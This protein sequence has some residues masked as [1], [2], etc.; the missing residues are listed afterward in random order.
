VLRK[1]SWWVSEAGVILFERMVAIAI[2]AIISAATLLLWQKQQETYFR[3]TEAA[4][5]QQDLRAALQVII[6][7]VRQARTVVTAESDRIV[8]QSAAEADPVPQRTLTLGT[9]SGC[10]PLCMLYNRGDGTGAQPIAEGLVA[11]TFVYRDAND[12]VLTAPVSAAQLKDIRQIDIAL[13]GQMVMANP[14]PPFSFSSS[15]KLRN[16]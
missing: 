14:D 6:R 8:F 12:V 15:I 4:Q 13:Q 16:R 10:V 1:R 2:A 5:V 7:D 11:L 9:V 3:G